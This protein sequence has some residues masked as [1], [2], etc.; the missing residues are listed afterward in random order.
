[1]NKKDIILCLIILLISGLFYIIFNINNNDNDSE[2]KAVVYFENKEVLKIDL[3]DKSYR[4]YDVLGY[5]GN[6]KIETID[7]KVRVVD[8]ISPYHLCSKK[9]YISKGYESVICLPNKV[10]IKIENS[11]EIDAIAR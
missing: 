10:I 6:V 8:E 2:K 4:E 3:S 7:G 1:M 5:N 11:S 9:G